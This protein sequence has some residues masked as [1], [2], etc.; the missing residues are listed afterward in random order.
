M[1][2]EEME[3]YATIRAKIEA[4][5]RM[6]EIAIRALTDGIESDRRKA[7]EDQCEWEVVAL[8]AMHTRLFKGQ[9]L[10]LADRIEKLVPRAAMRWDNVLN[11]LRGR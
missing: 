8:T 3:L 9:E 5:P 7:R 6:L 11:K 4:S 2:R 1:T 10:S